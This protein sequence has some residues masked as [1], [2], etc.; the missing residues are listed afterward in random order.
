MSRGPD[1]WILALFGHV[2]SARRCLLL[3]VERTKRLAESKQA[4]EMHNAAKLNDADGAVS[5]PDSAIP[6]LLSVC[7]GCA[8]VHPSR[9]R[10]LGLYILQPYP[11][12]IPARKPE[13]RRPQ[14]TPRVG[15]LSLGARLRTR[16]LLAEPAALA[17]KSAHLVPGD[18]GVFGPQSC[19]LSCRIN[20]R[21]LELC[22]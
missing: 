13:L 1:V 8:K 22:R 16:S 15:V 3:R 10:I 4:T 19:S 6:R 14:L 17:K 18:S 11:C 5:G 2:E 9:E 20:I 12:R 7:T 21:L